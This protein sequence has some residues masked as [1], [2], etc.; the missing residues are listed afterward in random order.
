MSSENIVKVNPNE[1]P[2]EVYDSACRI[3]K[4]AIHRYF[5]QP[6]VKE[7]YEQWKAS[8]PPEKRKLMERTTL[9]GPKV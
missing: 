9:K 6:E 5:E 4:I 8:L 7:E 1:I 2:D 3:L